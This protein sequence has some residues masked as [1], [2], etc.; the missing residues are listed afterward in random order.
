MKTCFKRARVTNPQYQQARYNQR[1]Y[2]NQR[3]YPNQGY[4][5]Q[6]YP[7][8]G[9]LQ[10]GGNVANANKPVPIF[11]TQ[12]PLPRADAVKYVD[13]ASNKGANPHQDLVPVG[14]YYEEDYPFSDY[15]AEPIMDDY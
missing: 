8:Q 13:V 15:P 14:M 12:P 11:G 1:G 9:N 6:G 4:Q 10:V 2:Q 5:N 7:N 3:A